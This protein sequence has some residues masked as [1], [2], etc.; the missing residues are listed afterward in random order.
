MDAKFRNHL[1]AALEAIKK[2]VRDVRL[3]SDMGISSAS[4]KRSK[5]LSERERGYLSENLGKIET[6]VEEM[7]RRFGKAY[8]EEDLALTKTRINI[9]FGEM[10]S[11]LRSIKKQLKWYYGEKRIEK[12]ENIY[13]HA[14]LEEL[15]NIVEK[16]TLKFSWD[17]RKEKT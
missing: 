1:F 14:R 5:P 17:N 4:P 10:D 12:D 2:Y 13:I 6:I 11:I 7:E 15:D 3:L 8:E 9:L 16:L